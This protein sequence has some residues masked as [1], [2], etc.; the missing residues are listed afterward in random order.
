MDGMRTGANCP[1]MYDHSFYLQARVKRNTVTSPFFRLADPAHRDALLNSF[2]PNAKANIYKRDHRFPVMFVLMCALNYS[3]E[4]P[5]CWHAVLRGYR[6][7][8]DD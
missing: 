5:V 3:G 7:E 4:G 2:L 1:V 6:S 8:H